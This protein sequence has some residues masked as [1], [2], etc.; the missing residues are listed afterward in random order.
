M[1]TLELNQMKNVQ[2]NTFKL[3]LLLKSGI[4]E[5]RCVFKCFLFFFIG[6]LFAIEVAL[7]NTF[8][9]S[10]FILQCL[11]VFD[12]I[13]KLSF[14]LNKI[15]SYKPLIYLP[16]R[17]IRL[18][19][20]FLIDSVWKMTN[21]VFFLMIFVVECR[22]LL[23]AIFFINS[24]VASLLRMTISRVNIY[25]SMLLIIIYMVSLFLLPKE[26]FMIPFIATL[27][28]TTLGF[29]MFKNFILNI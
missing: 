23:V 19:G 20:I 5:E 22:N 11:V 17:A 24:I 7:V 14:N 8:K 27:I 28:S 21:I 18:Y 6:L 16:I 3:Y 29:R 15:N 13:I 25:H 12:F 10:F 4:I 2:G 1:K 26:Q 9:K